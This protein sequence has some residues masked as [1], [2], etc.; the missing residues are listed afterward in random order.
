MS[1]HIII[2]E[3]KCLPTRCLVSLVLMNRGGALLLGKL[4]VDFAQASQVH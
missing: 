2:S 4:V 1:I 3:R